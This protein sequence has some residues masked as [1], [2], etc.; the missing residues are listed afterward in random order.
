MYSTLVIDLNLIIVPIFMKF[1]FYLIISDF[2][3]WLDGITKSKTGK[4]Q[5]LI[6]SFKIILVPNLIFKKKEGKWIIKTA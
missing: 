4:K 6:K 5:T 1:Y 2:F 3:V